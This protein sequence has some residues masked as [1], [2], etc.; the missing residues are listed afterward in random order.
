MF[1]EI[2]V[3]PSYTEQG[4]AT[5]KG[6]SKTLRILEAKARAKGKQGLRQVGGGWLLQD[7]DDKTPED[8]EF[9][10]SKPAFFTSAVIINWSQLA[11]RNL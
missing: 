10:V 1:Y 2:V 3:A 9:K 5:L 4:L 8:I 7:A 11:Y 6:K